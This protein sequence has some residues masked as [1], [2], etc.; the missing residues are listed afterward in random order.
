M[1]AF[2]PVIH[3]I[4][5]D[6]VPHANVI[7]AERSRRKRRAG[8]AMLVTDPA[9]HVGSEG[10]A[11]CAHEPIAI[12]QSGAVDVVMFARQISNSVDDGCRVTHRVGAVWI[13]LNCDHFRR[14][15]LP[16]DLQLQLF[17]LWP[18]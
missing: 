10:L 12:E 7:Y 4:H 9:Y 15:A 1:A 13:Q 8:D 17:A 14:V 11:R 5:A 6:P 18:I 16:A 3:D 2:D